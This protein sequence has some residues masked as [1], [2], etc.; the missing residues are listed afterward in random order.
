MQKSAILSYKWKFQNHL[1]ITY[2]SILTIYYIIFNFGSWW[3]CP[4]ASSSTSWLGYSDGSGFSGYPAGSGSPFVRL[5]RCTYMSSTYV[6][7]NVSLKGN[8]YL[9]F[10]L[11][12]KHKPL[13]VY[14]TEYWGN[15]FMLMPLDRPTYVTSLTYMVS[16]YQ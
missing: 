12:K 4:N 14:Q 2:C 8:N 16:P 10:M 5:F 3:Y 7:L 9:Q 11:F 15:F 13:L 6:L 1:F